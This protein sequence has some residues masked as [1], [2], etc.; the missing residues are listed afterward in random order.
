MA[1]A[2]YITIIVAI[3]AYVIRL[4]LTRGGDNKKLRRHADTLQ[5]IAG[6]LYEITKKQE[7]I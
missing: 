2:I 1:H 4:K 5:R 6:E 7:G 3:V